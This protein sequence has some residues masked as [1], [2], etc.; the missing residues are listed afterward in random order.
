VACAATLPGGCGP[1]FASEGA[2]G[3][4]LS[5]TGCPGLRLYASS[6]PTRIGGQPRL[7]N[8]PPDPIATGKTLDAIAGQQGQ[9][10]L[11]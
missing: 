3:R 9:L 8:Q 11:G 6:G 10:A 2:G 1:T 7:G 4:S 5:H